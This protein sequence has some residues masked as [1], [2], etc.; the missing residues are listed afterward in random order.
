MGNIIPEYIFYFQ[1]CD[2]QGKPKTRLMRDVDGWKNYGVGFGRETGISNVVKSYTQSWSFFKEDA[3]YIRGKLA[4]YGPNRRIRLVIRHLDNPK[5]ETYRTEYSGYLD[6]TQITIEAGR[7]SLPVS[8]AGLFK[9][10]ENR[11][12]EDYRL[13]LDSICNVTGASFSEESVLLNDGSIDGVQ[14][15]RMAWVGY[16]LLGG[17]VQQS[18]SLSDDF[19]MDTSVRYLNAHIDIPQNALFDTNYRDVIDDAVTEDDAFFVMHSNRIQRLRISFDI[20]FR[21]T[22]NR[23]YAY[24]QHHR[25]KYDLYLVSTDYANVENGAQLVLRNG[26]NANADFIRLQHE[27]EV[28][29]LAEGWGAN[30]YGVEFSGEYELSDYDCSGGKA[31]FLMARIYWGDPSA[32]ELWGG[33][34]AFEW[35]ARYPAYV[36]ADHTAVTLSYQRFRLTCAFESQIVVDKLVSA[37]PASRVFRQLVERIGERYQVD[38]D[39]AAFENVAKDDLLTSGSGLRGVNTYDGHFYPMGHV[40]TSLDSFLKFCMAVYNFRLGVDY[41]RDTDRYRV[42]LAHHDDFYRNEL[43][44]DMEKVANVKMSIDRARLYTSVRCGYETG[45]DAINGLSEYNCAFRWLTPNTEIEENELDLVSP[46]SAST[47]TIETYIYENYGD[48]ADSDEKDNEVFVIG[49]D[50]R[51]I[52]HINVPDFSQ[53]PLIDVIGQRWDDVLVVNNNPSNNGGHSWQSA[54]WYVND[55]ET[56]YED[57]Y[58]VISGLDLSRGDTYFC[59]L[60]DQNGDTF[61][62]MF[63]F[64]AD[65]IVPT[66]A[67]LPVTD[68]EQYEVRR[69][70]TATEGVVYPEYAWNL[71]L[72]PKRMLMAHRR[73]LNSCLAFNV[74]GRLV[75]NTCERNDALV[76][77]G[78]AENADVE[79]TDDRCYLPV[80]IEADTPMGKGLVEKIEAHRTG[81]FRFEFMGRKYRGFIA[82]GTDSAVINPM[83]EKASTLKLLAARDTDIS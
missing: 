61:L 9:A 33:N 52:E 29:N 41:D 53:L 70:I 59:V 39:L 73:E 32:D 24:A 8:E 7:V 66:P 75:M 18:E 67:E 81:C 3:A 22:L 62:G 63:P 1:D 54:I 79:I 30:T 43:I 68:V 46:Y 2:A 60:T 5:T 51:L 48:A 72:T 65:Y 23:M 40:E 12:S 37:I 80:V 21:M 74:G 20:R 4:Q 44:A 6:L 19:F 25:C 36:D 56:V 10:L 77:D 50:Y 83:C 14:C 82:E 28:R 11:W 47:R 49:G 57:R 35:D 42:Y 13:Q 55:F 16:V 69:N 76:A 27:I 71:D 64:D 34:I 15:S 38:I 78:L 31:F 17:T 26:D 45:D 58:Q